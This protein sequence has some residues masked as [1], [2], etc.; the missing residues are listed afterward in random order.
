VLGG[1]IETITCGSAP[2]SKDAVDFLK[3]AFSCE[4]YEGFGMTETTAICT[5][6]LP[7]DP[8]SSG[9]VGPPQ[10]ASEIKLVDVPA[11]GYTS[12][13][14]PGPR[15]ELCCRGPVNLPSYYKDPK[16]TAAAIDDE[17]WL[18]SG[19]IAEIDSCG[20]I[21]IIDRMKNIMKLSQGEYVALE[22][23][24]NVYSASPIIAQI[25]VHGDSLQDHL[26][27]VVIPD[28]EQL[29]S[30]ASKVVEKH[31]R[32]ADVAT[33]QAVAGDE[34]VIKV[35]MAELGRQAQ[36]AGLRGFESVK[37]IHISLEPFTPENDTLTPTL[38][39][40][41]REAHKMYKDVLDAMYK[42]PVGLASSKL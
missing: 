33:L 40:K 37:K 21:M 10:S 11:M 24:E 12:L 30:I 2:I 15:G 3:I 42:Q 35:I 41:R 18:H 38:K 26:V 16:N 4:I 25:Y 34:R 28:Q 14:K 31:V 7:G 23:I 39:I 5:K 32:P 19:D 6:T 20:R 29:A 27:A 13:D 8:G 22:K 1:Q 17:G 9:T 36:R